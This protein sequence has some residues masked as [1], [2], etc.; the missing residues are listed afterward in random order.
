MKIFLFFTELVGWI[1]IVLSPVFIAFLIGAIL[2]HFY[3]TNRSLILTGGLSLVGLII[4]VK[5]ASRVWMSKG[6][7]WY[8][9]QITNSPE[10]DSEQKNDLEKESQEES[11][12]NGK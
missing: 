5:W 11:N 7:M 9:S 6:T 12:C 8:L 2:Y 4:G 3:P 10:L 1:R